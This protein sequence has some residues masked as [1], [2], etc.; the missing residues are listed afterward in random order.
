M[1]SLT[2]VTFT[3]SAVLPSRMQIED[4]VIAHF[5]FGCHVGNLAS[6]R[7]NLDPAELSNTKDESGNTGLVLAAEVGHLEIVK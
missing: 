3:S 6:V 7:R 2:L 5:L 4:S 1:I